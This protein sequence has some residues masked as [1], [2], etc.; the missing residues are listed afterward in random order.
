MLVPVE[1]SR[2][3][4]LRE[5]DNVSV[6]VEITNWCLKALSDVIDD[7][8]MLEVH[9]LLAKMCEPY[10]PM[11]E[12]NLVQSGFAQVTPHY[13]QYG[14]EAVPYAH[15]MYM[16]E[17]YGPNI[18]IRDESGEI[19][20]WFSKP[21]ET[22]QPTGRKMQYNTEMHPK[23]TAFWDKV[24]MQEKGDEFAKQIEDILIRRAKELYG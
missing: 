23:A 16:G 24:M 8:S 13:V 6:E 14:N 4:K 1:V 9:N 10:V 21:G 19:I 20:G 3:T 17:I 5:S 12:G 18:P 2:I 15:Y 11:V 22:K 7:K